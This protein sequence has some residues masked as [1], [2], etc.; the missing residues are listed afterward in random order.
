MENYY[1]T[2]HVAKKWATQIHL[3]SVIATAMPIETSSSNV[4][5]DMFS[6]ST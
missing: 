6:L 2:S 1:I 4:I 5:I 3:K